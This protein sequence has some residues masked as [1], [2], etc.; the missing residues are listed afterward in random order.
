MGDTVIDEEK[1]LSVCGGDGAGKGSV[2][3][4]FFFFK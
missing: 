1:S 4:S 3:F 2:F